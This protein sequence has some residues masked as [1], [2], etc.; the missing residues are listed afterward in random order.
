M[1]HYLQVTDEHGRRA[2]MEPT[3][4]VRGGAKSAPSSCCTGR[5]REERG[6]SSKVVSVERASRNTHLHEQVGASKWAI[7]DSNL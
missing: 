1:K 3:V 2:T 5:Y 7:Q 6:I 4:V